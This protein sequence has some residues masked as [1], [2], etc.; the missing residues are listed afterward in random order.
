[1]R[2]IRRKDTIIA[3]IIIYPI[4]VIIGWWIVTLTAIGINGILNFTWL[5]LILWFSIVI[6][7]IYVIIIIIRELVSS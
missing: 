5:E 1:M 7:I 3:S 2:N 6:P 4:E